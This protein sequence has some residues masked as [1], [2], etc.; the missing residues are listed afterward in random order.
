MTTF[1]QHCPQC[2]RYRPEEV[3]TYHGRENRKPCTPPTCQSGVLANDNAPNTLPSRCSPQ[4]P[5]LSS[6]L[7][8]DYPLTQTIA[9]F[10]TNPTRFT[11]PKQAG[12]WLESLAATDETTAL[13]S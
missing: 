1:V 4:I 2:Q 11:T 12:Q 5:L 10:L 3:N 7:A 6:R 9:P 13:S 8:S